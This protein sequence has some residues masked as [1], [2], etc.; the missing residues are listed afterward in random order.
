MRKG[1]KKSETPSQ[2]NPLGLKIVPESNVRSDRDGLPHKV[3]QCPACAQQTD[4]T[5]GD[6]I[7]EMCGTGL[8]SRV[9]ESHYSGYEPSLVPTG[10]EVYYLKPT[11]RTGNERRYPRIPC[12]NVEACIKTEQGSSVIVKVLNISR[13]GS[14]FTGGTEFCPGVPV[15]IATHYIEGGHNIYQ[16]GRIIR[17]HFEGSATLPGVYGIEFSRK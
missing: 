17:V 8:S 5:A 13:G 9:A 2:P 10:H 4:C 7:C 12:R 14:C 11:V 1:Y 6:D 3:V 15:A 16:D